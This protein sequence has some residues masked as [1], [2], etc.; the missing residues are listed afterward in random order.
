MKGL[1]ILQ[2]GMTL[3]LFTV[4]LVGAYFTANG[5][6]NIVSRRIASSQP[7]SPPTIA[8]ESKKT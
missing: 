4:T 3:S 2:R 1:D 8:T 5:S 7:V 6:Y